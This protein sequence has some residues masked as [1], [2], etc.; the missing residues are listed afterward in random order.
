VKIAD[1]LPTPQVNLPVMMRRGGWVIPERRLRV[2]PGVAEA[3][4]N[5]G[6]CS[7]WQCR[8]EPPILRGWR[9][10]NRV[11]PTQSSSP[12]ASAPLRGRPLSAR[13]G[14]DA[15]AACVSS[16][17]GLVHDER[18]VGNSACGFPRG[19]FPSW[20]GSGP[21]EPQLSA[22]LRRLHWRR[23][24][25]SCPRFRLAAARRVRPQS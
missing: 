16:K 6:R 8:A 9:L 13:R 15:V 24:S 17:R 1:H 11:G 3:R 19:Q 23:S 21:A 25:F 2:R 7:P 12:A 22:R 18:R 14:G 5:Y 20:G 4:Q 10:P